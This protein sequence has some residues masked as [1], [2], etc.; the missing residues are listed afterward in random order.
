LTTA[1]SLS[2]AHTGTPE[3]EVPEI[4]VPENYSLYEGTAPAPDRWWE[5]F[6]SGELN[7]LVGKALAG[8]LTIRSSLARLEQ[9]RALA[10]E[11]GAGR[12]PDL[13]L[14]AGASETRRS[15]DKETV[16]TRSKNLNLVSTYE[17]DFWGRIRA[18]QRSALLDVEASQEDLYTAAMTLASEV[19]LKWLESLSVRQQL[20]LL[21]QQLK[22]NNTI[23][24][25]MELRY[26]KGFATALDIYQQRQIVAET[27]AG[28]PT[29]EARQ[30]TLS[31]EIAVLTG[32]PPLTDMGFTE[33]AFPEIGDLPAVGVPADLLARRPDVRSSGLKLM[34]AGEDLK[35]A[36][37]GRLPEVNLSATG[38]FSS[39]GFADL[40]EQWF[41]TLA[42]NLTYPLYRGGAIR[43]D[44]TR[45]EKIVDE[46]LA[47]YKQ[48]VLDAI[49][50]VE[51]AMVRERKQ[52]QYLAALKE[53]LTIARDSY[54]EAE[55]RYRKGLIDYLPALSA[56]ISS[57]RF[58]RTVVQARLEKLNQ[59][60]A[61]HRALGGGW[62][63]RELENR[64]KN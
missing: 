53:Q 8:N 51:D 11:A 30:E 10:V 48:T 54:R 32:N 5:E 2:C 43:A 9:S 63:A 25:L 31:H 15:V 26:L 60:V 4:T 20:A 49:R 34:A 57:Q 50:E 44:I 40:L 38:G 35:A 17:L 61:L 58:E 33:T 56:L 24:D 42:A 27:K 47:S 23:L 21:E 13:T 12:L 39:A 37:A 36:R 41:V 45:Q 52:S 55:Q 18:E 46:R 7:A 62:M 29:L 6:G 28:F 14:N 59:R 3:T 19:T 64:V 22:V 16:T 1:L